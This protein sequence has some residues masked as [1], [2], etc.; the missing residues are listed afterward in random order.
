MG[1]GLV[2]QLP[3]Q[4]FTAVQSL[5]GSGVGQ[6]QHELLATES[7]H[8]VPLAPQPIPELLGHGPQAAIPGRVT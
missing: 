3:A 7:K 8:A 5:V 4:Q 2:L 6:E 1:H